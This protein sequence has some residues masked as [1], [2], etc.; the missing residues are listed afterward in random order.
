MT[1]AI[2]LKYATPLI[3]GLLFW[4]IGFNSGWRMRGDEDCEAIRQAYRKGWDR[5]GRAVAREF[6]IEFLAAKKARKNVL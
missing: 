6:R 1:E 5:C 4:A 3:L 2:L